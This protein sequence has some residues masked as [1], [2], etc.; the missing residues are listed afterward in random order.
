MK[1]MNIWVS[2]NDLK[3]L[4]KVMDPLDTGIPKP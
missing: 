4:L 3:I 2:T 1:K